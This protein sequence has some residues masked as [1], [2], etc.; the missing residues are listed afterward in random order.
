MIL[1]TGAAGKTGRAIIRAFVADGRSVRA[2]VY[3]SGYVQ[4]V[5]ALGPVDVHVGDMRSRD[6]LREALRDTGSVYH[7]CP[8]MHPDEVSI[9]RAVIEAAGESGVRRFVYHSVLHPQIEAM[10]HHWNKLRVE[11]KLI[12][13]GLPFTILQPAAYMQNILAHA[14]AILEDRVYPV[15]YA[16]ETKIGMVDLEDVAEVAARIAGE[17]GHE[18]ATYEL[19]GPETLSQTEVADILGEVLGLPIETRAVPLSEWRANARERGMEDGRITTLCKMFRYYERHGFT[20][21]ALVL[22]TLLRRPPSRFADC[23]ERTLS[24][25]NR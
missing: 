13:S 22:R 2:L 9:G 14:D 17:A 15:P 10:P 5:K 16:P 23:A 12:E 3:R 20:G 8:N 4:R 18:G 21:N 11:E 25:P 6:V 19:C 24:G 7:I 1:V